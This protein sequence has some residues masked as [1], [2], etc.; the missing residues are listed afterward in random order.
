MAATAQSGRAQAPSYAFPGQGIQS[1]GMGMDGPRPRRP[2][3]RC[4][5]T[6]RQVHPRHASASRSCTWSATTRPSLIASGVHY[7][8]PD[9]RAV[10]DAVHPGRDGHP[11]RGPGRR[12]ARAGCL[13]RGRRSR[14]V[15]PS[16]STTRWRACRGV[17][18][19]EALLEV[20]FHR[21]SQMHHLVP[22]DARRP[23]R[24]T[25]WPRSA[26]RRSTSP[27][28]TSTDFVAEIAERTGEFLQI[29]NYNLRG[30]QYAIAGT[31]RG[32]EALE[33]EV[34]KR[35]EISGGKRVVHPGARHRRA[36]P[37]A[38]CCA[39]ASPTSAARWSASAARDSRPGAARR[40][41]HPEP[42][43]AAVHAGP[44]LR[45]GGPRSGA[46]RAARRDPRRLR[47]VAQR[48]A[49]ASCAASCSSSCWPGS[50]PARCAGSRPRTCCSSRRPRRPRHRALRRDRREVGADRRGPG[51]P[52]RS[53]CPSTRTTPPRCS[54]PSATPRCCSPPTPTR[55]PTHEPT[56][57][58]QPRRP[59]AEAAPAEAAPA[60]PTP[61]GTVGRSRVPTTSG[62]TP[63]TPP[64]R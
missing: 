22:R 43:A 35:R 24:T 61:A 36:V 2:R 21:G 57:P 19:L 54:T 3:A 39:S 53:S 13:R 41:L 56:S 60:P 32:L 38:R 58:P 52:T 34:E 51:R 55:N 27:T 25:A 9:G 1:Q 6:R 49:D 46:R 50:S 26:R 14:A 40:P 23:L 8:H 33:D 42:G 17:L 44:R 37:L 30:S 16:V 18:P 47:H 15:T 62:S 29:V 59:A 45:P 64:W 7:R 20:V 31:V 10:P 12:D 5:D 48:A 28:P 4:W 11:R 63:P